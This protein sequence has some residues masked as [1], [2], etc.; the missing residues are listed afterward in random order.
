MLPPPGSPTA[1][2]AEDAEVHVMTAFGTSADPGRA[3]I[4]DPH[5]EAIP[6]VPGLEALLDGV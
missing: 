4:M 6:L 2:P 5:P 1:P 3:T